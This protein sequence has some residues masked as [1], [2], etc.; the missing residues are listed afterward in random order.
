MERRAT[1]GLKKTLT[2]VTIVTV[3][4]ALLG[5]LGTGVFELLNAKKTIKRFADEEDQFI[6]REEFDRVLV[7]LK[8]TQDGILRTQKSL[9]IN[10]YA[11]AVKLNVQDI[12]KPVDK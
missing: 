10:V 1:N 4:L 11:I 3:S 7:Q 9:E 6:K 2:L 8:A 12:I 5:M